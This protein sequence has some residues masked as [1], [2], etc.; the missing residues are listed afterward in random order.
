MSHTVAAF[1]LVEVGFTKPQ[2]EA[3][4][5]FLDTQ[6]ATKADLAD[7]KFELIKWMIGIAFAQTGLILAVIKLFM[8][9]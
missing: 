3:L 7:Q 9:G 5:E 8:H 6:A 2:V 4:A 1:K